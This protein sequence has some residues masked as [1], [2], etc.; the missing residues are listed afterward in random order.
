MRLHNVI[1]TLHEVREKIDSHHKKWYDTANTLGSAVNAPPS[2]PRRC[3]R[4]RGRTNVPADTPEVYYRKTI[5][6]IPFLDELLSHLN[7]R[8]SETQQ[9]AVKALS[10]VPSILL[11]SAERHFHDANPQLAEDPMKMTCPAHHLS[12]KNCICGNASGEHSIS[13]LRRLKSYL[14]STMGQER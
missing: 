3:G 8:F 11:Q 14:R 4:Q 2:I 7:T 6:T 12:H 1:G 10:I 13:V 5:I 9:L